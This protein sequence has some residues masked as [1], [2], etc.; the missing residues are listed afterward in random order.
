MILTRNVDTKIKLGTIFIF[1]LPYCLFCQKM[2]QNENWI[3]SKR[4]KSISI[5]SKTEIRENTHE[6]FIFFENG[7]IE[8]YTNESLRHQLTRTFNDNTDLIY[9]IELKI[10]NE[11]TGLKDTSRVFH[12]IYDSSNRIQSSHFMEFQFDEK[13]SKEQILSSN[14]KYFYKRSG[15]SIQEIL[16]DYQLKD[17]T[18]EF[19]EIILNDKG[20]DS[21]V[22]ITSLLSNFSSDTTIVKRNFYDEFGRLYLTES[23]DNTNRYSKSIFYY[24]NSTRKSREEV[25]VYDRNNK[26][27]RKHVNKF[28]FKSKYLKNISEINSDGSKRTVQKFKKPKTEISFRKRMKPNRHS[29]VEIAY[30]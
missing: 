20:F 16:I 10:V 6:Q 8:N 13:G 3:R 1:L 17:T 4:I 11:Q 19:T 23:I 24:R 12:A 14:K 2:D 27:I 28:S 5:E 9:E 7:K 22:V 21:L 18:I 29:K 26:I 25:L 15:L 30:F